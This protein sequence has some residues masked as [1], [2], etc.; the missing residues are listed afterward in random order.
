MKH[1]GFNLLP[2]TFSWNQ[3]VIFF[4]GFHFSTT[5]RWFSQQKHVLHNLHLIP[6]INTKMG[7]EKCDIT[8]FSSGFHV[9]VWC[10]H[11]HI[12]CTINFIS[13]LY[14]FLAILIMEIITSEL[15]GY[16]QLVIPNQF[17][18]DSLLY[19]TISQ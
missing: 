17:H 6:R 14:Y 19:F 7:E 1:S 16:I 13:S 15:K 8:T 2:I 12:S 18:F 10:A 4:K 11:I 3:M 5:P 9:T